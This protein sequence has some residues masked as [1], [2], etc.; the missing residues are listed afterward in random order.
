LTA[1]SL[2]TQTRVLATGV[3]LIPERDPIVTAKEVASLDVLSGGRFLFGA[4]IGWLREEI[5]NHGVDPGV[6]GRVAEERL[7]AM[8]EIWTY[9]KA[10]FRRELVDF[11]PI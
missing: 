6:R 9:D 7:R 10:E 5:A 1:A 2:A 3:A 4:G 8:M 11:D